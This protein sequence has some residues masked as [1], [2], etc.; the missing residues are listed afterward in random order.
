MVA[1]VAGLRPTGPGSLQ[2]GEGFAPVAAVLHPQLA[3]K[4]DTRV[5]LQSISDLPQNENAK[6]RLYLELTGFR[7][8]SASFS[9]PNGHARS[10]LDRSPGQKSH[11]FVAA[12]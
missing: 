4:P 2:S 8:L 7:E 12:G 6:H 1:C 3:P 10:P 9:R 11:P 5:H